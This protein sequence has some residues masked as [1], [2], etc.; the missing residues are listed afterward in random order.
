MEPT[1]TATTATTTTTAPPTVATDTPATTAPEVTT[2]TTEPSPF[3]RPEWLG[4]RPLE[5]RDDDFGVAQPTP[6][7]LVDRHLETPD[8]LPPP[9]GDAFEW[10]I[11]AVPA[12]V[13]ARS[14]WEEGC[15]VELDELSYVKV[16]H[17]G[18]DGEFHTGEIIVNTAVA[19][20]VVGVF[21]TL[22]EAR[23]PIEEM[24]VIRRDELDAHP[25][26]DGNATTSFVCRPAV[27][28]Q[29]WSQH[30]FGLAI[31]LNPFHNPY[32]KGD[33]VLPEL[34]T[35]YTDRTV[36]LDGMIFAG[37]PVHEAF[38][39]IGWSWGGEWNSLKDWMHFSL[40]GN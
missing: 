17:L 21:R 14:T 20:D 9:S 6:A 7:E 28:S 29:N 15:P 5:L 33:L 37:D 40:S 10:T 32:L 36:A 27:N 31:D 23:F 35:A 12:D 39:A 24:R 22:H 13:V 2:S 11:G 25:T 26:G 19:E 8:L 1:V 16:S 30:A 4:T 3:A 38:R 18:F 34:A